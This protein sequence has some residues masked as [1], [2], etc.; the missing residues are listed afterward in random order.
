MIPVLTPDQMRRVDRETIENFGI[1][2]IALMEHAG[3]ALADRARRMVAPGGSAG[4]VCGKG[5][6]GGDGFVAARFLNGWNTSVRVYLTTEPDHLTGDARTTYETARNTGVDIVPVTDAATLAA[7]DWARHSLL[8]D[9]ILGTGTRG[10]ARGHVATVIERMNA[11]GT[12]ILA[13]DLPS[14]LDAESGRTEGAC[15]RATETLTMGFPKTGLLLYPG[16]ERVGALAVADIGFPRSVVETM[17]PQRFLLEREDAAERVPQRRRNAH[18][19]DCG[20]VFLLC[21]SRG[22]TGAATLAAES[23]LRVGAGLV[24]VGIPASLNAVMAVKLTEA[25][26]LSLPETA[27]G[28]L[29]TASETAIRA[30]AG[31][32]D[33]VGIGSGLSQNAETRELVR[34]LFAEPAGLPLRF[35]VDADALNNVSPV[36]QT[37]VRFPRDAILT[38]HPGEMARLLGVSAS[39]VE[40]MRLESAERFAAEH[41]VVLVL[42]GVPTVVASPDGRSYLN[43]TGHPGMAT[44]GSGDVLTGVLAGLLAQGLEPVDAAILGVYLHGLAGERAAES[45]GDGLVAGDIVRGLPPTLLEL[46]ATRKETT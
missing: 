26:S 27:D 4:I 8:I 37:A 42:K 34:R 2:G 25:M 39:D 5:N 29:S 17:T 22:M 18:K 36:A 7:T 9:C 45:F 11:S 41:G 21:G 19:G 1:P 15:V 13:C 31:R 40:R 10:A 16:A 30:Y 12:P 38:P 33:V 44:G 20:R 35:V 14:G 6:N 28:T 23:A 43:P 32:S 3:R 46:T 24:T